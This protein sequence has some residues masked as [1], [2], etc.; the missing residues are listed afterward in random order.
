MQEGVEKAAKEAGNKAAAQAQK[1]G[2]GKEYEDTVRKAAEDSVRK[3]GKNSLDKLDD[4]SKQASRDLAEEQSKKLGKDAA[5]KTQDKIARG[6]AC[7]TAAMFGVLVGIRTYNLMTLKKLQGDSCKKVNSLLGSSPSVNGTGTGTGTGNNT[8]SAG[9]GD[10]G[11]VNSGGGDTSAPT[12]DQMDTYDNCK[13]Q[14]RSTPECISVAG[15]N[16][17]QTSRA[18]DANLLSRPDVADNLLNNVPSLKDLV[19]AAEVGGAGAALSSM[20][21]PGEATDA[22]AA[23]AKHAQDQGSSLA[24]Q[25]GMGFAYSSGGGGGINSSS[26]A[27]ANPFSLFGAG[28]PGLGAGANRNV[29][30]FGNPSPLID[31]WHTGT[32][33]NLFQIVSEKIEK[34]THRVQS[35]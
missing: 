29:A 34:V 14:G 33:L 4:I 5:K 35:K 10:S 27:K 8:V 15:L 32:H 25:L 20:L 11:N 19:K 30:S 28:A 21:P 3:R 13:A 16:D 1:L 18:T 17:G 6:M 31:I 7:A 23:L 9:G 2:Y 24:D 22:L 12:A 26:A